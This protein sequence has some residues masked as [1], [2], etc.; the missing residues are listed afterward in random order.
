MQGS[1]RRFCRDYQVFLPTDKVKDYI[2]EI[3]PILGEGA[4][5]VLSIRPVG[6]IKID[7]D[8]SDF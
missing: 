2:D 5:T 7:L 1:W 8:E 6:T 3:E 4:V